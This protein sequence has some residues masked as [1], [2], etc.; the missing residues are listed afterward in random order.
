MNFILTVIILIVILSLIVFIHEFGHF[1]AA[2]KI[3]VFVHEFA[4]GMGPKIFSFRRKNDETEYSLRA[5]PLG[6]FNAIANDNESG[7]GLKKEQ[8]LENKTYLQRFFVLIMGIVFNFLLAIVLF[9]INGLIYGS[10]YTNATVGE[11]IPDTGAFKGGLLTDDIILEIN[12]KKIS[13]F[14]DVLLETRYSNNDGQ[15][16][17]L[18]NRDGHNVNLVITPDSST[19]EEGNKTL[20][21]GFSATERRNHGFIEAVKYGFVQTYKTTLSVFKILGKLFTGKLGI[22]NLS[23]PVGVY[24]VI[25]KVKENGLENL[26]YLTAYLSLNVA[27]INFLPIPVFDGGRIL[28]LLIERIKGHKLNPKIENTLNNIGTILLIILVVYVTLNDILKLF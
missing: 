25:D 23:G 9:F 4:V 16:S 10:P 6:G 20:S 1:L 14:D 18:V 22:G 8:I 28:L 15:F 11:V 27:V 5:L 13:N 24:S 2:K 19:D 12:G 21:F 3:K 7:E 17:F 26:I